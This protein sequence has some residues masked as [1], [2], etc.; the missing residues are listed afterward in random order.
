MTK[1]LES[2]D[3]TT[4]G[5]A[6]RLTQYANSPRFKAILDSATEQLNPLET[7]FQNF[8]TML[9]IAT[10]EGA[11]LDLVGDILNAPSRPTDDEDFRNLLYGLVAA[12][13]ATGRP[14]EIKTLVELILRTDDVVIRDSAWLHQ[15]R[16]GP[17]FTIHA[18]G[19][20]I[21]PDESILL[22][23]ILIA[24]AAGVEFFGITVTSGA[25]LPVFSFVQDPDTNGGPFL[26]QNDD[27]GVAPP[28]SPVEL[29]TTNSTT[30][31][32]Q[33]DNGTGFGVQTIEANATG[34]VSAVEVMIR[35]INSPVADIFLEIRED[36]GIQVPGVDGQALVA[37]SNLIA[38]ATVSTTTAFVSFSFAA[39]FNLT[40]LADYSVALKYTNVT[41]INATDR[42]IWAGANSNEYFDGELWEAAGG[43]GGTTIDQTVTFAN[44]ALLNDVDEGWAQSFE[45]PATGDLDSINFTMRKTGSPTGVM[46]A[47][48][49]THTGGDPDAGSLL[50]SSVDFDMAT[51]IGDN[52]PVT[53]AWSVTPSVTS[54]T[55]YW[56][57]FRPSGTW[58]N[59]R[60]LFLTAWEDEND[61]M[62]QS[63]T[64]LYAGTMYA[65]EVVL[66]KQGAPT[67]NL[68]M[69]IYTDTGG[70]PDSGVLLG[71]SD[72]FDLTTISGFGTNR[73]K[74]IFSTTFALPVGNYFF[75]CR[76]S[77]TNMS[78][79]DRVNLWGSNLYA[80]GEWNR[81]D[82][83]GSGWQNPVGLDW[84]FYLH[85]SDLLLDG[86]NTLELKG[87]LVD[88]YPDGTFESDSGFGWN[89]QANRDAAF[90]ITVLGGGP[91]PPVQS[92][93]NWDAGVRLFTQEPT[94]PSSAVG[95]VTDVTFAPDVSAGNTINFQIQS[96]NQGLRPETAIAVPFNTS[97]AQTYADLETAIEA[98][99]PSIVL[100]VDTIA[101]GVTV[102]FSG[103]FGAH[104][105]ICIVTGGA[106]VVVTTNNTTEADLDAGHYSLR[107]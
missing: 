29:E 10:A 69:D 11:N 95:Q 13:N 6:K 60:N 101:T 21:P 20:V 18:F 62:S 32:L 2:T 41:T 42:M 97:V 8:K 35:K 77:G 45:A 28:P 48:L 59:Q 85:D 9:T 47:F 90:E 87:S 58:Q 57:V 107:F 79:S 103:G 24:K 30:N 83:S 89:D 7:E 17:G 40:D 3:H 93:P 96:T 74:F 34:T 5:N 82:D 56:I 23:A 49:Y 50:A 102:N 44:I 80:G 72:A 15:P 31:L 94:P 27:A 67:G 78:G 98:A 63:W 92:D 4:A 43:A 68:F 70:D 37:T 65:I 12:Y 71:T 46:R 75:V 53:F 106:A 91:P 88:D 26:I 99:F 86:P 105:I 38:A 64:Q 61:L 100:S 14:D 66:Q 16:P 54:G 51:I 84:E 104:T 39:P 1:E 36:D 33:L 25:Y 22:D 52:F 55:D 81:Y 19:A 73:Y 76:A